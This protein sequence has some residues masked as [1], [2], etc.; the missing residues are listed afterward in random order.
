MILNFETERKRLKRMKDGKKKKSWEEEYR[1]WCG[2]SGDAGSKS[3]ADNM[4]RIIEMIDREVQ[5]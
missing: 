2:V 5:R 3:F 4:I 1:T